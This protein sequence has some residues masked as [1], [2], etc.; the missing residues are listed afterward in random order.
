MAEDEILVVLDSALAIEINVKQL[1][2]VEGLSDAGGE[3]ES[4]HLLMSDLRVHTE[5]LRALEGVDECHRVPQRRQQDVATGLIRFRLDR[6]PNVVALICN[7]LREHVDSLAVALERALDV[8]CRV[9][10]GAFTAAPHHEGLRAELDTEFELAHGLAHR[11][12]AH[13]AVVGGESTVFEDGGAE[14]VGGDHRH[15]D[16]GVCH[17]LLEAVD[18]LLAFGVRGAE[19]E[20]VVVME[21]EAVCAELSELL[22]RVDDVEGCA[23]RAAEGVR[24]VVSHGPESEGELIVTGG[25]GDGHEC[26]F[27]ADR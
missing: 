3:V 15:D 1:A 26:S 8:F 5:Q 16:P 2:L 23:R 17:R 9:V 18:L 19:G 20:E 22:D 14:K 27:A 25:S 12:A 7:V 4:G 13:A 6:E 10:L 24:A 21:G 11:V